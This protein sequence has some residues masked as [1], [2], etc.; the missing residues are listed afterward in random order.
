MT[1]LDYC[2]MPQLDG[3]PIICNH[4]KVIDIIENGEFIAL[5]DFHS[6][7]PFDMSPIMRKST[8]FVFFQLIHNSSCA[9]MRDGKRLEILRD[10]TL[11]V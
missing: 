9:A 11:D 1:R 7:K 8:F 5:S 2:N 10:Y 3:F 6:L 4:F